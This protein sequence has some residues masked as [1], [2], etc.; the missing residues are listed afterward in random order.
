MTM[1]TRRDFLSKSGLA[2]AAFATC[3]A[4]TFPSET[5]FAAE[6]AASP[7][8]SGALPPARYKFSLAAYSY[9][10]LLQ[11]AKAAMTLE[12]FVTDCARAGFD[13]A[14]L[15]SYYFPKDAT[16]EYLRSIKAHCFKLGIDITGTAVGNDF[17]HPKGEKRD[18]QIAMVK[19]WVDNAEILGAPQIRIFAGSVKP[20]QTEAEAHALVVE[21]VK[22]CCEYA[23]K[24]GIFLAL[25]NHG[26]LTA[27]PDGLLKLMED[28]KNPW[29][30]INFDSG[31]FHTADPYADL[32]KI[33]PY[34]I[35]AQV[36][37]VISRGDKKTAKKEE[38]DFS[39]LAK[40]LR[41][42]KYRGYIVLEYEEPGDPRTECPK[43][44]EQLRS[45]FA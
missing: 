18:E 13:G 16:P 33:A 2:A 30:G 29:L 41:E 27:T 21:G 9:R 4:P 28:A 15:T 32:E 5:L 1:P 42:A 10:G 17:T 20:G 37:V 38:S 40:M 14:E 12:D 36:K 35:N 3:S 39:R 19:R 6:A 44:L 31:N 26:G 45:T 11:G 24:H 25:E 8:T 22:E 43:F 34:A 23:G 7:S